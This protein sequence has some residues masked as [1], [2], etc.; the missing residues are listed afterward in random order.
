M[1]KKLPRML[2][3]NIRLY[4]IMFFAFSIST[5]FFGGFS[6]ELG[7]VQFF[8]LI[9]LI[10]Y[11]RIVTKRRTAKLIDYLESVSDGMDLTIRDIPLPVMLYN[12]DTDEIIWSNDKFISAAG[13][14]TPFFERH[15]SDVVPDYNGE[16]LLD[17]RH[18]YPEILTLGQDKYRVFGNM[19]R[20]DDEYFAAT[21]WVNLSAYEETSEEYYNS[22]P[23]FMVLLLDNYD[24][25]IKGITERE[26]AVLISNIDDKINFWV[27]GKGGFICRSDRDRYI[28]I[29]EDRHLDSIKNDNFSI[30]DDVHNEVSSNGINATLCIGVGKDGETPNECYRFAS[31]GIEMALSRGGDQAVVRN[32]YGFEFFGGHSP[33][34]EK[35]TKVR[36]RI[37]ANAFG[38]L[39]NDASKVY[40]MGH[41]SADFDSVGS[42]IGINCIA[43]SKRK[44]AYIVI[45]MLDNLAQ[46][47]ISNVALKPEYKD[48]FISE[49]DAILDIDSKSLLVVVDTNRLDQVESG[50][51]L[52]SC[53][54]VAVI[55]HHRRSADYIDDAVLNFHE[56]HASSTA[57]LVTELLQNLVDSSDILR[58]EA[59]ALL[60][61]LVLDTKGF[62][63]NTGSGTFEAAAF[64]RRIGAE[65]TAVKRLLQSDLET[66][67]ARYALMREA[68]MYKDGITIAAGNEEYSRVEIAQAADEL[69]NIQGVNTS[70][71]VARTGDHVYVSGRS[72]GGLN[73]Q[74]VLEKLG[75]G[76]SQS[77]AGLQVTGKTVDEVVEDLKK[78]IDSC[79]R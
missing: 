15:I 2:R 35:R 54:R 44:T 75:G 56:P 68:I 48:V 61:G 26:K 16:W 71:A 59:E 45:D 8:I 64:L 31:L 28:F 17:R 43:R 38:E 42:A 19:V 41:K 14:K 30:L 33:Q 55:D 67:T 72:I 3:P 20:T 62:S 34:K 36:S 74:V 40:I 49:Q 52:L 24:E 73:V 76:G 60:A 18:E 11:S 27:S 1:N 12:P 69:L 37:I 65:V 78:A 53:T 46:D 57:E 66:T 39:L 77:T 10:I 58:I 47:M 4:F 5:F 70:F 23:V 6:H 79:K 51:L 9:I 29:F 50:S 63:I 13:L 25:L 21:Y 22:R 32:R 7:I